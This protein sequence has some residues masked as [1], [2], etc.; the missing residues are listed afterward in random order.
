MHFFLA[1]HGLFLSSIDNRSCNV[2]MTA[3]AHKLTMKW[4]FYK[5]NEVLQQCFPRIQKHTVKSTLNVLKISNTSSCLSSFVNWL[6]N[7]ESVLCTGYSSCS[8]IG[9]DVRFSY[10]ATIAMNV[11]NQISVI[12]LVDSWTKIKISIG[13]CYQADLTVIQYE[14]LEN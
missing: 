14:S 4:P 11:N 12:P 9:S 5:L 3:Y 8:T 7:D 13:H 2:N 1:N 10:V 6:P